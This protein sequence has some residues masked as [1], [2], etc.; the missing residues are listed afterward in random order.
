[1]T[2]DED[3]GLCIGQTLPRLATD[4]LAIAPTLRKWC[5]PWQAAVFHAN[6][7]GVGHEAH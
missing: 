5:G 4:T 2:A 3:L 1:V 7:A 6:A